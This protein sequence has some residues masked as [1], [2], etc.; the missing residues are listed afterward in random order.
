MNIFRNILII[1]LLLLIVMLPAQA[2]TDPVQSIFSD[3]DPESML[4]AIS[5]SFRLNAEGDYD[6]IPGTALLFVGRPVDLEEYDSL[7]VWQYILYY[8]ANG[9]SRHALVRV[10]REQSLAVFSIYQE[11][12]EGYAEPA[13]CGDYVAD[14]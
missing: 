7:I 3:C 4:S 8:F 9:E 6:P 10:N 13:T 2:Q 14:F 1:T 12:P 11:S 5:V